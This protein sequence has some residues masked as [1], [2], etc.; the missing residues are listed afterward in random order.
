MTDDMRHKVVLSVM[1]VS[2]SCM[3]SVACSSEECREPAPALELYDGGVTPETGRHGSN[4][5]PQEHGRA[6][7]RPAAQGGWSWIY[8]ADAA[9]R[10]GG[11]SSWQRALRTL[12]DV[13]SVAVHGSEMR[14]AQKPYKSGPA[15]YHSPTFR[16]TSDAAIR[17]AGRLQRRGTGHAARERVAAV[18]LLDF[19]EGT[20]PSEALKWNHIGSCR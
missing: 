14:V 15:V 16:F 5:L 9:S 18:S 1:T 19:A 11:G 12:E 17:G 3:L 10:G 2:C 6:P 7:S 4:P 8:C 20:C 13:F